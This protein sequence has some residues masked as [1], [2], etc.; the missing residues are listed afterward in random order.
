ML[1]FMNQQKIQDQALLAEVRSVL[2]DKKLSFKEVQTPEAYIIGVSGADALAA[3]LLKESFGPAQKGIEKIVATQG[4]YLFSAREARSVPSRIK[5]GKDLEIGGNKLLLIAGPCSIESEEQALQIAHMLRASGVRMMRGGLFKPR[6]SAFSFQ[7]LGKAGLPILQRIRKETGLLIVSEA[8]DIEQ[9]EFLEDHVD[10][11][12]IG[13]RSMQNFPLL[14]RAGK[15]SKPVLLKRGMSATFE[16]FLTAADYVLMGGNQKLVLCERGIRTFTE[17]TR[18]TLDLSI[19]PMVKKYSHLPIMVDPSHGTGRADFVKSMA[20]AGVAAGADALLVEVHADPEEALSDG[21]QSLTFK[22]FQE[23]TKALDSLCPALGRD[24]TSNN[25][26]QESSREADSDLL[27]E[28]DLGQSQM[29]EV[30]I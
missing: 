25:L 19:V 22:A 29:R 30:H 6:T 13:S 8:L 21:Q 2:Q 26:A 9:L 16:E 18:N 15:C 14:R 11:I 3:P 5:L 4:S 10:M 27:E 17:H 12:Q 24:F 7:G 23:L 28:Q 20:L 1:I